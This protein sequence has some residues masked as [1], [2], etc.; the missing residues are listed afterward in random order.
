[1]KQLAKILALFLVP[2]CNVYAEGSGEAIL[3]GLEKAAAREAE[4]SQAEDAPETGENGG[5]S[6][7]KGHVYRAFV[8]KRA[9]LVRHITVEHPAPE[10]GYACRVL[11]ETER[12]S[13]VPWDARNQK[14]YCEP[15]AVR[16]VKKHMDAGWQCSE[17]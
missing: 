12:G 11:Y 5:I 10:S 4:T 16:L 3:R 15:H 2:A 6:D 1:M 9:D 17:Q 8:C 7:D 14:N 13:Q